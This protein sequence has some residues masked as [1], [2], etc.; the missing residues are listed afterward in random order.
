[1]PDAPKGAGYLAT[2]WLTLMPWQR[3]L[4]SAAMRSAIRIMLDLPDPALEHGVVRCKCGRVDLSATSTVEALEHISA[5]NRFNKLKPHNTFAKSIETIITATGSSVLIE[6]EK[7]H[8][9]PAPPGAREGFRMDLVATGVPGVAQRLSVDPTIINPTVPTVLANA[10]LRQGYA[11]NQA[12]EAKIAKYQQHIPTGD[13]FYPGAA[14]LYGTACD[15]LVDL[16]DR[17]GRSAAEGSRSA[18]ARG[19][20][21]AVVA[22]FK[23]ELSVGLMYARTGKLRDA[24]ERSIDPQA[25]ERQQRARDSYVYRVVH[26]A[27]S[28]Y[29]R[30]GPGSGRGAQGSERV[31][32]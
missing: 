16:V 5:C 22:A 30:S 25:A 3:K 32:G 1:M 20:A 13:L 27:R 21:G 8:Y 6:R 31:P 7:A 2:A 26:R 18:G 24:V 12:Q 23:Q 15:T 17:L 19:H 28:F 14:E 29:H 10:V 9:P 11:A 4:E